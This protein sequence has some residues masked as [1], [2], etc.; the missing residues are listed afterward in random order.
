M[1]ELA[2][3]AAFEKDGEGVLGVLGSRQLPYKQWTTACP[4]NCDTA[5]PVFGKET[6]LDAGTC[7]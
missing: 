7:A 1:L 2:L 4:D 6:R 3:K 5:R